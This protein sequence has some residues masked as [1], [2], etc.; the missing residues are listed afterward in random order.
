MACIIHKG[1]FATIGKTNG[2]LFDW[3]KQNNYR[4]A[5]VMREIYHKGEWAT[6]HQE[7]YITE[8]QIPLM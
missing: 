7:E 6:D 3:I 2:A 8:L 5:G 4:A 1:S